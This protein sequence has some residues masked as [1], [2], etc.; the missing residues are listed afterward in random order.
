MVKKGKQNVHEQRT[1]NK[2]LLV[3]SICRILFLSLEQKTDQMQLCYKYYTT[4][5]GKWVDRFLNFSVFSVFLKY[6]TINF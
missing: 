6:F 1:V 4:Q 3:F 5:S 2:Y